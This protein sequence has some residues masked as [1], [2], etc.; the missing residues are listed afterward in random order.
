MS[1]LTDNLSTI[2]GIKQQIKEV[3]GTQSDLFEEYPEIISDLIAGAGGE[4]LDWDDVATAGYIIPAGTFNISENGSSID[5]ASYA[6]ANVAVPIPAGYI[7]PTGTLNVSANGNNIDVAAYA[8]VNVNVPIPAGYI[9]PSGTITIDDNEIGNNVDVSSYQY[10]YIDIQG[11]GGGTVEPTNSYAFFMFTEDSYP[12]GSSLP[13]Y[14]TDYYDE[15][16]GTIWQSADIYFGISRTPEVM[17][18]TTAQVI[19][20]N[21]YYSVEIRNSNNQLVTSLTNTS[22]DC[23]GPYAIDIYGN[24]AASTSL[25][26]HLYWNHGEVEP[27]ENNTEMMIANWTSEDLGVIFEDGLAVS[28]GTNHI[29]ITATQKTSGWETEGELEEAKLWKLTAAGDK[30]QLVM[31][32][33]AESE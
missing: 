13:L 15:Y 10:A 33:Q 6:Y 12:N 9:V 8:G 21:S 1:S 19:S 11:G 4:G 24:M 25:Y 7:V 28:T 14:Y 20:C 5:V 18:P 16:N 23:G 27:D 30:Y 32:W 22:Y 31:E 3:I 17:D 2:Y 29:V 26:F